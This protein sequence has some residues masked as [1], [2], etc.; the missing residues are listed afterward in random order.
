MEGFSGTVGALGDVSSKGGVWHPCCA[1]SLCV[2]VRLYVFVCIHV[3]LSV[4]PIPQCCCEG[5]EALV[6]N[7]CHILIALMLIPIECV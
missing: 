3:F 2:C 1:H 4:F 5:T 6:L 7:D